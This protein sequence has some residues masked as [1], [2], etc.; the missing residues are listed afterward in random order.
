M[1]KKLTLV[2]RSGRVGCAEVDRGFR[3]CI[4]FAI[5]FLQERELGPG[6]ESVLVPVDVL[7]GKTG[8]QAIEGAAQTT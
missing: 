1:G 5:K 8:A 4:V 3:Q 2:C 6:F 7:V